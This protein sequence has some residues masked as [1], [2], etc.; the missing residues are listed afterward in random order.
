[1]KTIGI[2][3]VAAFAVKSHP[4]PTPVSRARTTPLT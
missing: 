4:T 2:V 1:V 3:D